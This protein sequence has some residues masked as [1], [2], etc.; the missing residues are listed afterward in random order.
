MK[1]NP[2][3]SAGRVVDHGELL[4]T[5]VEAVAVVAVVASAVDQA[6]EAV[7]SVADRAAVM[8]AAMAVAMAAAMVAAAEEETLTAASAPKVA[9]SAAIAAA[10]TT[11]MNGE[12][13]DELLKGSRLVSFSAFRTVWYEGCPVTDAISGSQISSRG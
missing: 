3:L 1:L 7:D 13:K 2:R 9:A 10:A 11:R 12:A 5:S 6:A 8:A 4:A